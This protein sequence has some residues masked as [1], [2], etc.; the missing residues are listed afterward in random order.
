MR[1]AELFCQSNFSFLQGASHPWELIKTAHTLGYS[2]L[3]ITDECSLSGIVRAYKELGNIKHS[4]KSEHN[5]KKGPFPFKLICGSYFHLQS[6]EE[7][8]LLAPNKRAYSELCQ[9][10]STS[11][12]R[13]KKGKYKT[14]QEDLIKISSKLI[15]IW[16]TGTEEISIPKPIQEKFHN[17]LFFA[18]NNDLR[19]LRS[20]KHF[21]KI[22]LNSLKNVFFY[23]Q[24]LNF[25]VIAL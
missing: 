23:A 20:T 4:Q 21:S 11:R 18:L 22:K 2:A 24:T 17:R 25:R 8:V 3:A 1:Y 19:N 10:I 16:L 12:L 7:I 6:G 13:A 15:A 9:I 5:N 14:F